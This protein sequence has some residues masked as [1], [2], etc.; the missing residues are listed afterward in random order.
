MGFFDFLK[1]N[2]NK[3]SSDAEYVLKNWREIIPYWGSIIARDEKLEDG[4]EFDSDVIYNPKY[5]KYKIK[6]IELASIVAA[7]NT[8]DEKLISNVRTCFMYLGNFNEK[9][10]EKHST[11]LKRMKDIIN[12]EKDTAKLAKK[13]SEM[14]Y[15]EKK[16][17]KESASLM[18]LYELY[19]KK[20]DDL[21][22][23]VK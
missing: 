17:K 19:I 22:K 2:N 21:Y 7:K 10:K 23:K 15:D 16:A 18:Q 9:I 14:N 13:I 6:H 5:L 3:Q 4:S 20:F 12:E 11:N 1:K 8:T